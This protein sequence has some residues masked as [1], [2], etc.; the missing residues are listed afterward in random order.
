MIRMAIEFNDKYYVK[1]DYNTIW[2][3]IAISYQCKKCSEKFITEKE[4]REHQEETK[5]GK[6]VSN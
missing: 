4:C 3:H 2:K 5:H 1:H 6:V